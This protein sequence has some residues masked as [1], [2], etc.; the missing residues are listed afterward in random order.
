[1]ADFMKHICEHLPPP[2][3]L[4][5]Q[6]QSPKAFFPLGSVLSKQFHFLVHFFL[7]CM[8]IFFY[9]EYHYFLPSRTEAPELFQ[10]FILFKKKGEFLF[11]F[12]AKESWTGTILCAIRT[13][14]NR[15]LD[16]NLFTSQG[17]GLMLRG[18][19]EREGATEKLYIHPD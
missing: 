10:T 8:C 6:P 11:S 5:A 18:W 15:N 12:S 14:L 1:M 2:Q 13:I 16:C 7:L 17:G 3:A 9:C 19:R 4:L